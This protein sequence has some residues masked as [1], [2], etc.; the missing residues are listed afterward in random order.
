LQVRALSAALL[1]ALA[2]E[3][4]AQ[5]QLSVVSVSPARPHLVAAGTGTTFVLSA[6]NQAGASANVTVSIQ[7]PAAWPGLLAGADAVFRPVGTGAPQLTLSIP[8]GQTR[9]LVAQLGAA[10]TLAEGAT[11]TAVVTASV[12]GAPQG[13]VQ[14]HARVRNRPKLF[15]VALDGAGSG[16]LSLDKHGNHYDGRFPRLMPRA[17]EFKARAALMTKAS[18]LLPSTTDGNHA[19]ALT[20]SWPGTLG[21]F[22]VKRQYLGDDLTGKSVI[23]DGSKGLLRWGP[24]GQPIQTMFDLSRN[25]GAGGDPGAFNVLVSGKQ[26]L[27]DLLRDPATLDLAVGAQSFPSYI[28]APQPYR[29]GDPPSD[30]NPKQDREGTNLGPASTLHRYSAQASY[31]GL[32]PSRTPEDRWVAEAALRIIAAEDPDVLYVNLADCDTVQHIFGAAD[33]PEEWTDPGT[34]NVLWD[35]VNVYNPEAN[36][37]PVLD[38]VFEADYDFGLIMDLLGARQ[39][40]DRAYVTLLSDHGAAT[41]M[42]TH[43][44]VL[45]VARILRAAGIPKNASERLVTSGEMGWIAL[46]DPAMGPRIET[47]LQQHEEDDPVLK[48][49]VH[50]FIV[51]N[52]AEMDSGVDDVEGPMTADG[53][54]ANLRGE[55]YSEWSVDGTDPTVPKVRWPDLFIFTRY[56]YQNALIR[57]NSI[58]PSQTGSPFNGHHGSRR[59]ADVILAL[60]GPGIQPGAY[61]DAAT[62][63]D[64]A[65][66]LY[67]LLGIAPPGHV[68][69]K[70]LLGIL[71]H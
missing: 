65:P 26:W 12:Q 16:Y 33:R 40:L 68:D 10:D 8:G 59:T 18:G 58:S 42:H 27:A 32:N 43:E 54:A 64:L 21:L 71:A 61:G 48:A 22:S 34:P 60:S 50:P 52:R 39:M 2:A 29:M 41:V 35:D 7:A 25:P 51:L 13:T 28:P 20:G 62:L 53:I 6:L 5:V 55:L 70:A 17:T 63:A 36:R 56:N 15:Y 14:L 66:T 67:R 31:A 30:D 3:A 9:F 44:T 11:A 23:V 4:A 47:I 46:K 69:G 24:D 1:V 49:R 45:D 38:T 19:A 37:D 57:S